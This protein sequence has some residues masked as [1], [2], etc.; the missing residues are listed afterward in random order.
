MHTAAAIMASKRMFENSKKE[1][2][3]QLN[4]TQLID[5]VLATTDLP[6]VKMCFDQLRKHN[7]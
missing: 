1:T 4:N 6:A 2:K 3:D 5:K 7:I